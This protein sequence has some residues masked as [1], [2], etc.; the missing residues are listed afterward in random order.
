M[1]TK[2]DNA[3]AFRDDGIAVALKKIDELAKRREGKTLREG[4]KPH[5]ATGGHFGGQFVWDTCFNVLWAKYAPEKFPIFDSLDNLYNRQEPDGFL[6][7]ESDLCGNPIWSR[8]HP[9]AFNPPLRAWVEMNLF[10][11]GLSSVER[12]KRIYPLLKKNYGYIQAHYRR[13]DGLYFGD[14]LGCG[15]DDLPRMPRGEIPQEEFDAG[16]KFRAEYLAVGTW[17][18]DWIVNNPLYSWNR[19]IGWIDFTAQMALKSENLARMAELVGVNEDAA[20]FR[21]EY[22][23]LKRLVNEKCWSE[24]MGFYGDHYKG[25]VIERYHAGAFWV[26]LAGLVP[27]E[28]HDAVV[29]AICD[30]HIFN[31]VVPFPA[32]AACDPEY[33][34]EKHYWKGPSWPPTSYVAIKGLERMGEKALARN[35]ALKYYRAALAVHNAVGGQWENL[36]SAQCRTNRKVLSA[37]DYAG[38]AN[39]VSVAIYEEYVAKT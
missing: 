24:K 27:P 34:P 25:E 14:A 3:K 15:M 9:V 1:N 31:T 10:D 29:K 12:L 17:G 7:R 21:A 28:R 5:I 20:F 23:S 18:T 19:Q 16:I 13:P 33:E 38:W 30:E 6:C 36:S 26:M 8:E 35:L 32:L 11:S 22:D 39:L 2:F 4:F 37:C